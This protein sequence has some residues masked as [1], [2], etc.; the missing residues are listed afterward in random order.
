MP[1]TGYVL[2]SIRGPL[3]SEADTVLYV[4]EVI[5]RSQDQALCLVVQARAAADAAQ[6]GF[7]QAPLL[8]PGHLH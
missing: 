5:G 8:Q 7:W 4:L 2:M 3:T 1:D 6:A